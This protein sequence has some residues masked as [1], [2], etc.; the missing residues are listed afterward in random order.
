MTCSTRSSGR[1]HAR[2][3][4]TLAL[5]VMVGAFAGCSSTAGGGPSGGDTQTGGKTGT[6]GDRAGSGGGSSAG[7]G[8][9]TATGGSTGSGSGGSS[10]GSGGDSGSGGAGVSPDA[11]TPSGGGGA[12]S[13]GTGGAGPSD[14]GATPPADLGPNPPFNIADYGGVGATP[15]VPLQYPSTPT[16]PLI[17]MECPDDPTAGFTEYKG[18]FKVQRPSNLSAGD[19][20]S[21]ENGIY[22]FWIMSNDNSHSAGNGTAPRTEARYTDFSSGA[23]IWSADMMYEHVD[24]TCVMQIH[25][26]VGNYAT[27]L[28]ITGDMMFDLKTRKTVTTGLANKWFNMKVLFDT[29]SLDVKI[30]INNCLKFSDKSPKGPTPNWY[31]K[32]GV[33]TCES[34]TCKSHYKNIHLYQKGAVG[35]P[36]MIPP[37]MGGMD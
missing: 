6:G 34:G 12:P 23:H 24:K 16:P 36:T 31:F 5:V 11:A 32:H 9:T 22:N 26:E 7:G 17:P 35:A 33:Y 29:Q 27:Y 25:N 4:A 14:A 37:G 15:Y 8:G 19:R 3:S 30:Y 28:R 10:S 2:S 1:I 18:Q 21:Y 13:D 20:F